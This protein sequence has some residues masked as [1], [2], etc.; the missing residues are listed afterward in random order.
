MSKVSQFLNKL[1][2]RIV[3][4]DAKFNSAIIVAGGIGSRAM[5]DGST[6]QMAPLLGI[7]V[8]ARTIAVFES[9][10]FIHEIIVV[11]REDEIPLYDQMQVTYGWHK[12]VAVVA[13]GETRQESVL[14]GFKSISDKSDFVYIHDAARCLVT[15]KMIADVGHAAVFHGA[16]IAAHRASDTVK[17]EEGKTLSTLD[18]SKVWLAQTPQVFMTDLYRAAAYSALKDGSK[19][20]DD[21]MMAETLGFSVIP[22]ECGTE[23]IK[24]THPIDF[25]I[26]E[27]I[28]NHRNS[29][30]SS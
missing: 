10:R 16:A 15:Q 12:V 8:V 1:T 11:A 6:K 7:P 9:C 28:L 21:A 17:T 24:I 5:T 20:T 19:V 29:E 4:I 22:V 2:D 13:G 23:N 18:R 25:V 27:A 14:R 3:G 26:A 30:V